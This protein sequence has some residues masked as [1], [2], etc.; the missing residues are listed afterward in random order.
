MWKEVETNWALALCE[1]LPKN[2]DKYKILL[3]N[4][5]FF[6]KNGDPASLRS[7]N[8]IQDL[9]WNNTEKEIDAILVCILKFW[10]QKGLK[11]KLFQGMEWNLFHKSYPLVPKHYSN[12]DINDEN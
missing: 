7:F 2:L 6:H 1:T 3:Q 10:D 11:A 12:D 9:Q 5:L 8:F 4:K